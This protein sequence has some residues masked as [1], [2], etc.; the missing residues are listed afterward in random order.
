MN[1]STLTSGN[2]A[3]HGRFVRRGATA[4]YLLAVLAA[5]LL[6][7]VAPP[8]AHAEPPAWQDMSALASLA[9][10]HV[11]QSVGDAGGRVVVTV[12]PPDERLRLPACPSALAE[13][14]E[15]QRLWGWT[16]VRVRCPSEGGWSL[17]VR[18]RVQVMAPAVVTRRAVQAG[19]T[20]EATDVQRGEVDLTG[21]QRPALRDETQVVGKIA[22]VGLAAGQAVGAE[23]LKLPVVVRRGASLEVTA[24]IGQVSVTSAGTAM[25]DGTLGE[26]IR[27]KV[28]GGRTVQGVVTGEGRVAIQTQ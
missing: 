2:P 9:R 7:G 25:Q 14:P 26:V 28:P 21:L 8:G 27:V 13:T 16:Q 6:A 5:A 19:Q 1:I 23:H 15:G 20:L 18:T 11:L 22:R 12:T 17:S 4:R 3:D 10:D 24:T